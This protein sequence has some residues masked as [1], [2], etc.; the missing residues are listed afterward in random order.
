MMSQLAFA[1]ILM[2]AALLVSSKS[3]T[4]V[5]ADDE[6]FKA[7]TAINEAWVTLKYNVWKSYYEN[8][9]MTCWWKDAESRDA[10]ARKQETY[11]V[12]GGRFSLGKKFLGISTGRWYCCMKNAD[13][14]YLVS[15]DL[16]RV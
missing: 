11:E 4:L 13:F 7:A 5:S 15:S 16:W 10:K 14:A 1:L 8:D 9:Y 12:P 3:I 2:N 6:Q